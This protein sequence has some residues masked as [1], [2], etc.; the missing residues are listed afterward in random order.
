M[1]GDAK[2][3]SPELLHEKPGK[4]ADIFSLGIS[5][6][7]IA[8]DLDLPIH[9]EAWQMLR[10]H[11]LPWDLLARLSPELQG[12]ISAMLEPN[13][14][15]RPSA[16]ALLRKPELQSTLR[17]RKA[18]LA[19]SRIV[20]PSVPFPFL[21]N[22]EGWWQVNGVKAVFV[23]VYFLLQLLLQIILKPFAPVLRHLPCRKVAKLI[24]FSSVTQ[25]VIF[26]VRDA[27][28]QE[29]DVADARVAGRGGGARGCPQCSPLRHAPQL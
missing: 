15:L 21:A 5:L 10:R 9:G 8:C 19:V 25:S 3:L 7:E 18:H 24:P 29:H 1:K 16:A 27:A 20:R 26:P 23:A 28:S 13:P 22:L 4:A 14:A 2:Y 6:L 17:R 12:L 11:R